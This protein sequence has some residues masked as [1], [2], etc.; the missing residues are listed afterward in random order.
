MNEAA[1]E[2]QQKG[3]TCMFKQKVFALILL[4]GSLSLPVLA[5]DESNYRSDAAVQ[6]FGSFVKSNGGGDD[7]SRYSATNSGG[8]LASYRYFFGQHHGVEVN[9]GYSLNSHNYLLNSA[10]SG[11]QAYSHEAT[12]AYVLRFPM[13]RFTPFVLAGAGAVVFDPKNSL[14][15]NQ[16]RATFVYGG[17]ADVNLTNR[18][19]FRAQYRGLVYNSPTFDAIGT[20]RITHR[21]VPS[22]GFG[23]RF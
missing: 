10:N 6:A 16:A 14:F 23:F 21:A 5:Q 2:I 19:F 17:G 7:G 4:A 18:I 15:D 3:N 8:V 1:G 11:V 20:E 12:A 22:A 13:K 9:Y